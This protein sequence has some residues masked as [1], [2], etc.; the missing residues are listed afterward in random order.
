[1]VVGDELLNAND[2]VGGKVAKSAVHRPPRL[3]TPNAA[4]EEVEAEEEKEEEEKEDGEEAERG[5][6]RRK[7]KRKRR[8]RCLVRLRPFILYVGSSVC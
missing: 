1:M 8:R 7:G 5:G 3:Q 4:E 2:R 6:K